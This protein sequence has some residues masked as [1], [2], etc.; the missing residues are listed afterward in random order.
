MCVYI[1][2]VRLKVTE[3]QIIKDTTCTTFND[4]FLCF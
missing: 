2:L 3:R 1:Q 4:G